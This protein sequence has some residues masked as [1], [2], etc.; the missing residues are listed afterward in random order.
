MA[1]GVGNVLRFG[2]NLL[3][4]QVYIVDALLDHAVSLLSKER[5]SGESSARRC[6]IEWLRVV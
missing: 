6:S 4:D 2:A 1:A 5:S 3:L